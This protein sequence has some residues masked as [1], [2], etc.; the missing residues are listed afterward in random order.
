MVEV[1]AAIVGACVGMAGLSAAGR[2]SRRSNDRD[3][4][5]RLTAGVEG[6]ALKLEDLYLTMKEDR[7]HMHSRLE[8]HDA[9][10]G[11]LDGQMDK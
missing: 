6:I 3:A 4:V 10:I 8:A 9:K 11:H 5:I 7:R 2:I 1:L